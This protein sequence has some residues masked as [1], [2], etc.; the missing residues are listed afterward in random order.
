MVIENGRRIARNSGSVRGRDFSS[1]SSFPTANTH[2]VIMSSIVAYLSSFV[3][4]VHNDSEEKPEEPEAEQQEE[5]EE[6]E[7]EDVR[8]LESS[9]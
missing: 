6:E 3:S 5:E 4:T 2:L 8:R 9:P 7:P 1:S